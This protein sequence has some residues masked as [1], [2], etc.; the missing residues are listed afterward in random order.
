MADPINA[1]DPIRPRPSSNVM[2]LSDSTSSN[3][4]SEL[5]YIALIERGGCDFDLKVLNAQNANFSGVIVYNTVPNEIFPMGGRSYKDSISIPAVMVSKMAGDKLKTFAI[6][7]RQNTFVVSMVSFYSLPLKYV[8]LSL[9]VLVGVSL[10]ILIVCFAAHL[11]NMWRRMRRG[12]LSRRHLRRLQTK[13][14][15][16][17]RDPYETCPICLEDYKDREKIRLLPC[18]HAFHTRCID[19]WL[20]RNRRR[21]PVCNQTVE[22]S[23]APSPNETVLAGHEPVQPTSFRTRLRRLRMIFMPHIGAPRDRTDWNSS[24]ES[25][26]ASATSPGINDQDEERAPLLEHQQSPQE[27]RYSTNPAYSERLAAADLIINTETNG[28]QVP[29]DDEL[30]RLQ[31]DDPTV[32]VEL[33]T[34]VP[35][36][37]VPAEDRTCS[38]VDTNPSATED[39]QLLSD[40]GKPT[41]V[42]VGNTE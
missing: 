24:A 10:I 18:H 22:L 39:E 34:P 16:K 13:R 33:P 25:S 6:A 37:P 28:A 30:L 42:V 19:P 32:I 7:D 41:T 38:N 36:G 3:K 12:R 17:A 27:S 26:V 21:C 11:C 31:S 15:E 2:P 23:G 14:F 35:V 9:L 40:V 20:L 1:C 5:P 8:L 29:E 4:L